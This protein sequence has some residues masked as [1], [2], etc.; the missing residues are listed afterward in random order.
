MFKLRNCYLL[1]FVVVF[2]AWGFMFGCK[3]VSVEQIATQRALNPKYLTDTLAGQYIVSGSFSYM[4]CNGGAPPYPPYTIPSTNLYIVKLDSAHLR[5]NFQPY[6]TI[7]SCVLLTP[8]N[9]TVWSGNIIG[10][11]STWLNNIFFT[12]HNDSISIQIGT[13][14]NTGYASQP[15]WGGH[16]VNGEKV[17]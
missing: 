15:C 6:F 2:S 1:I 14:F 9:P 17:L 13:G 12:R 7:D 5:V 16:S 4:G 10:P 3:K 11:D 8:G